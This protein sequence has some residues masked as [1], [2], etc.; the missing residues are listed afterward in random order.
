MRKDQET[1]QQSKNGNSGRAPT[2]QFARTP[3]GDWQIRISVDGINAETRVKSCTGMRQIHRDPEHSAHVELFQGSPLPEQQ[4]LL[5]S[6][7]PPAS[8]AWQDP[9]QAGRRAR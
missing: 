5:E 6:P 8:V 7:K 1:Q 9:E 4:A 2:K 3:R